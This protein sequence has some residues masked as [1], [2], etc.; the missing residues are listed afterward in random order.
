MSQLFVRVID[1][2]L[3]GCIMEVLKDVFYDFCTVQS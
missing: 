3:E 1:I 2:Y